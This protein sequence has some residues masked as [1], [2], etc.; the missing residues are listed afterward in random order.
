[1][2]CVECKARQRAPRSTEEGQDQLRNTYVA[3]VKIAAFGVQEGVA[4]PV[5]D[6]GGEVP[7]A[8]QR[9][10]APVVA[11]RGRSTGRGVP[12]VLTRV[13]LSETVSRRVEAVKPAA[14]DAALGAGAAAAVA[15]VVAKRGRRG[16]RRRGG[17]ARG[18]GVLVGLLCEQMPVGHSCEA[19]GS[20][21][22]VIRLRLFILQF[23]R[24]VPKRHR[25]KTWSLLSLPP[26]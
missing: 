5:P 2:S 1:M 26:L 15:T 24:L 13:F 20:W 17:R 22:L 16:D 7:G 4:H 18:G 12:V 6:P 10:R 21:M 19:G 9:R 23:A 14:F 11:G 25:S 8:G 3:P